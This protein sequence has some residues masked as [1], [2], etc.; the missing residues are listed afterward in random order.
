MIDLDH[1][2][3]LRRAIVAGLFLL[4]AIPAV[5]HLFHRGVFW[6][7]EAA[8]ALNIGPVS[9]F[10]MGRP[11]VLGQVC[12]WLTMAVV[13]GLLAVFGETEATYRLF[14]LLSGLAGVALAYPLGRRLGGP[15][16][17]YIAML[18]VGTST[19]YVGY[20]SEF[21]PYTVD[22]GVA[23]AVSVAT[24]WVLGG[25][26]DRRRV[27]TL[28]GL[29]I[30][31]VWLSLPSIFVLGACGLAV[32]LD[33]Q[34]RGLPRWPLLLMGAAWLLSFYLHF[35]V[36][37]QQSELATSP[38]V[39]QYWQRDM[40]PFPPTSL[41][42]LR[43]YVG[44]Y[45]Y[46]FE[47]PLALSQRYVGGLLF[48]AGAALLW[49]G[50]RRLELLVLLGPWALALVASAM[51]RYPPVG[52]LLIFMV[53]ALAAMLGYTL[54]RL[55]LAPRRLLQVAGLVLVVGLI[56]PGLIRTYR[57]IPAPETKGDLKA[58]LRYVA[59]HTK[60]GDA[61][62]V[63]EGGNC[64]VWEYYA[65]FLDLPKHYFTINDPTQ[66]STPGRFD[67]LPQIEALYGKPR[68][69]LV[70]PSVAPGWDPEE[71]GEVNEADTTF[72]PRYLDRCGGRRLSVQRFEHHDVYLYD[73]T[74]ARLPEG[75]AR[76]F[77][78]LPGEAPPAAAPSP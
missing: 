67:H 43:W 26:G 55:L 40:A 59:A 53:P 72:I 46:S 9:L 12:P 41:S 27:A 65:P 76:Y 66:F 77:N 58:A 39:R 75:E 45:F 22:A 74:D 73:L 15:W 38:G 30:I 34:R 25:P 8:L 35:A 78:P 5:V 10:D 48:A 32:L 47:V 3:R 6:G 24:L 49:R 36:F 28:A 63:T 13:K 21:K 14:P 56:G 2:P 61:H 68:V 37:V 69:W 29:G 42:D 51:G 52:R 50:G 54:T 19:F 7:D 62:Y 23:A 44:R 31:A 57:L 1:D 17:G 33:A 11:F 71:A 60:P 20:T 4:C 18:V 64:V 16:A 70:A